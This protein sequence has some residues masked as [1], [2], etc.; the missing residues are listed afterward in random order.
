MII[1]NTPGSGARPFSPL[2]HADW[3]G[4]TPT[5][6]VFPTF[7]F[8]VGN[9]MSF[10]MPRYATLGTGAVLG[11]IFK[12]TALIFL[13]GFL[14]YWFPFVREVRG[15]GYEFAPFSHT[16]VMGVLQRIALCYGIASLMI[17]FLPKKAVWMLSGIFLVGYWMLLYFGGDY[18][19]L[20]NLGETIDRA[21]LGDNHLYH[22]EGVP[23]DPEGLLSTFPS[24]VN[25]VVGYYAG[26]FV[27]QKGGKSYETVA[28]LMIA[29][30]VSLCTAYFWD[31]LFPINK[32]LWTSSFVLYTVGLD[33][34]IL[35]VLIYI[36]EIRSW[37][38]W[39]Y[40]FQVFG[41]NPL[42]IYLLSELLVTLFYMIRIGPRVSLYQAINNEFF[43]KVLPG[44]FGSLFF[45]LSYMMLCWLVG[46]WMDKRK[47]YVRV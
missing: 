31:L 11:K 19:M 37:N 12:R 28:R 21:I 2:L 39:T 22:G 8:A 23:F 35:G 26:L 46:Y 10:T 3:N 20:G 47:I 34:I 40:F 30:F 44:A 5:D 27:Q 4:F 43:Q 13:L 25:V 6:L 36:I 1:V 9:A 41:R 29:G 32:K 18:T 7:L 42:S 38:K 45:A 15:G 33:M 14:M 17:Y 16:R 24:V